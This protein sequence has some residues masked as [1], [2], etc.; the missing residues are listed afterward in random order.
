MK[1]EYK[2]AEPGS[3]ASIL[4]WIENEG[5]KFHSYGILKLVLKLNTLLNL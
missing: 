4:Y 5:S 1:Y 2:M 3:K